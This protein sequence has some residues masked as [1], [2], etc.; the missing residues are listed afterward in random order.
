MIVPLPSAAE[1]DLRPPD[2]GETATLARGIASAV[3]TA[4][5]LT[6]LQGVLLSA[7]FASMTGHQV[8][9]TT[10]EPID[11]DGFA[12]SLSRRNLAF[13]SRI[14]QVMLLGELILHPLPVEVADRVRRFAAAMGVDDDMID[15]AE[16]YASGALDVAAAD[17]ARNGYLASVN[18]VRLRALHASALAQSW[19]AVTGDPRLAAKWQSLEQLPVGT[20]G[21]G[22]T[23]FYRDRGFVYPGLPG[24]APPLLAQHDWVHVLAGYGTTLESELE[25]F[26][27]IARA[28]DDPEP[29][30][31]SP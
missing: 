10:A 18:P 13:R 24:S 7:V 12:E 9:P 2:A 16:S 25:V 15:V 26:A 28:N 8:D 5:G 22:V 11:P 31:C 21:R 4:Q 23:D 30:A 27:F 19:A 29:S 17:F 14:V 20:L 3:A 1:V 6:P